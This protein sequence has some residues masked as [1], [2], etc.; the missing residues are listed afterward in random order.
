MV[1]KATHSADKESVLAA[2]GQSL[3]GDPSAEFPEREGNSRR[4]GVVLVIVGVVLMALAATDTAAGDG[5]P[6]AATSSG[7]ARGETR[8]ESF[9]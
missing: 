3:S 7:E 9:I 4:A 1:T 6:E 2:N 8:L 5:A